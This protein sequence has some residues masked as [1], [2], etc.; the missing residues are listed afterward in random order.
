MVVLALLV[1]GLGAWTVVRVLHLDDPYRP[2]QRVRTAALMNGCRNPS[3][4][5]LPGRAW[6]TQEFA[7]TSWPNPW[8]TGS[9]LAKG[10]TRVP[11]TLE[12]VA[13]DT[14]RFTADR[15]GSMTFRRLREGEFVNLSCG[16]S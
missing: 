16:I 3:G 5:D 10:S 6:V 2:G 8:L 15:G 9:D 7:P 14:G 4:L 13:E 12:V 1:V 11:G